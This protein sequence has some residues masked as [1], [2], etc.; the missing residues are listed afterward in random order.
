MLRLMRQYEF[1]YNLYI[2]Y[3]SRKKNYF[4]D[5]IDTSGDVLD[6]VLWVPLWTDLYRGR[7]V[8]L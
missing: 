7:I 6:I 3:I 1:M 4:M 2:L 5:F 8:G